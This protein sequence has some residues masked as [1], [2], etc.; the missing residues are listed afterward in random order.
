MRALAVVP[1]RGGSRR[2]PRKNLAEFGGETLVRRAL[3]TAIAA[4]CFDVVALSTEDAEI[5]A[6]GRDLDVVV[7]DR[8]PELATDEALAVDV[9]LHALEV[10]EVEGRFDAVAVVQATSPFTSSTDVVG[11]VEKLAET[12]AASVVS[13]VK[14]EAGLHPLKL[15]L[16]DGDR[17]IPY[18]AE[19]GL[20]P[21]QLLPELW[22]RNGS[23]YVS[24]RDVL[25][26]GRLL[27]EQDVR[28]Y[29]MPADRSLDID[30]PRDLAFA[31]F[32]L[33][34]SLN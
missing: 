23:V 34:Q 14:V 13:V 17:L 29:V 9:V 19:D 33:E 27:D 3:R 12:S 10:L 32:L 24:R 2:V 18:L 26:A 16:L 25:D 11:A 7:L 6:E 20:A 15:K 21:S 22:M 28:A 8:P 31:R 5:A 30:T 4:G 1:A